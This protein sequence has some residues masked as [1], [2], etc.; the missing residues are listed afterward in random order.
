LECTANSEAGQATET[1]LAI[2]YH[3]PC[4]CAK[5]IPRRLWELIV[6]MRL[7]DQS[8]LAAPED[9]MANYDSDMALQP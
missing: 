4:Y 7:A 6:E 5:K 3:V 1:Q 9:A 8:M 2:F